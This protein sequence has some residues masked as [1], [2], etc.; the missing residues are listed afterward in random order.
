[1]TTNPNG[2]A[3]T[4]IIATGFNL[5]S[6]NEKE[7]L[8]AVGMDH[9]FGMNH[10]KL[11]DLTGHVFEPNLMPYENRNRKNMIHNAPHFR[12]IQAMNDKYEAKKWF[13]SID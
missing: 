13:N 9:V 12:Q 8:N 10:T 7:A 3:V 1:M 11:Q 4:H 2:V 6:R 5:W